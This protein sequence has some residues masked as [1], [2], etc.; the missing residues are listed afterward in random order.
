MEI[1]TYTTNINADW[2][3][4]SERNAAVQWHKSNENC[5]LNIFF[6][7][8]YDHH[9]NF[10]Y[11]RRNREKWNENMLIS[12]SSAIFH[13]HIFTFTHCKNLP[14]TLFCLHPRFF[15]TFSWN[16]IATRMLI[17]S[18]FLMQSIEWVNEWMSKGK[19]KT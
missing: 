7:L 2:E 9:L 18:W 8:F 11:T 6:F 14:N 1:V 10:I 13:F 17:H 15:P 12:L 5:L 4:E 19:M 16:V 3:G